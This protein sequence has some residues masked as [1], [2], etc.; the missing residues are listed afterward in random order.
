MHDLIKRV[1]SS[2]GRLQITKST[3]PDFNKEHSSIVVPFT[4]LNLMFGY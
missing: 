1:E 3:S 2:R 4:I